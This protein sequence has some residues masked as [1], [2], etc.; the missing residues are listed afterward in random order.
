[1][2]LYSILLRRVI[3]FSSQF[4]SVIFFF[5]VSSNIFQTF[6]VD[7]FAL[8]NHELAMHSV[9]VIAISVFPEVPV[10][11]PDLNMKRMFLGICF[12]LFMQSFS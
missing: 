7:T 3:P 11:I 8:V 12:S 9:V 5:Q 4:T 10:L 1:M 2:V 6:S